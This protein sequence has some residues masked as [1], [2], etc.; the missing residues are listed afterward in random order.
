MKCKL[1]F[2]SL[3]IQHW[4]TIVY[5]VPQGQSPRAQESWKPRRVAQW[6][7]HQLIQKLK[8]SYHLNWPMP[9]TRNPIPEDTSTPEVQN[10]GTRSGSVPGNNHGVNILGWSI[11][12]STMRLSIIW[13]NRDDDQYNHSS[14]LFMHGV[15]EH[16]INELL[17]ESFLKVVPNQSRRH[18]KEKFGDPRCPRTRVP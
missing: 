7:R 10:W 4:Y 3:V 13:P 6:W 15:E 16:K 11:R 1:K 5:M 14:K 9:D 12:C 17:Q 18:M 8:T 2:R